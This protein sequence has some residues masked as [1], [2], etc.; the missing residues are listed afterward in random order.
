MPYTLKTTGLA[1]ALLSCVA[2]D[3]D[4]TIK[5]FVGNTI[6]LDTG[7]AASVATGS[8]KSVSRQYFA[9]TANGTFNFN[10]VRFPTPINAGETDAD[11][12]SVWFAAHGASAPG[13]DPR[14]AFVLIAPGDNTNRGLCRITGGLTVRYVSGG[15]TVATTTTSIPTDNSTK[16]SLGASYRSGNSSQVFYGLESGSLAS[17]A[18]AGSDG[19]FG[20]SSAALRSIGGAAGSGN[21]PFRPYIVCVFNRLLTES[22]MQSLHDDWFGVLFN[23]GSSF[24]AAWS[25]NANQGVL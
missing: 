5:D 16:F 8:W 7:V 1:T 23:S 9:T 22:E 25:R 11:G 19:A 14:A 10:G 20:S 13:S 21:Q 4:G 24:Q 2:V 15:G 6:T 3:D 12:L 17:E 18:T